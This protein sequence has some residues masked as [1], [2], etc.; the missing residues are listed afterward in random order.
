MDINILFSI[1]LKQFIYQFVLKIIENLLDTANQMSF[2]TTYLHSYLE[3]KM[4]ASLRER[5]Y[6]VS[7]SLSL[8]GTLNSL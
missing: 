3:C 4:I 2:L 5:S 7:L 6:S 1:N 8:V